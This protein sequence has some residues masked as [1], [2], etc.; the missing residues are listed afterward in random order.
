[1]F[2]LIRGQITLEMKELREEKKVIIG[3]L[4]K[5]AGRTMEG[6]GH[7]KSAGES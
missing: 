1:M 7:K 3:V 2:T 6:G 4:R 5:K